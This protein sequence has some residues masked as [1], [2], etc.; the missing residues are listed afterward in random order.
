MVDKIIGSLDPGIRDCGLGLFYGQT[1]QWSK[2]VKNPKRSGNDYAACRSM[3]LAV[4][5]VFP[6]LDTLIIEFPRIYTAGK[7]VKK[8]DDGRA[9]STNPNDLL[10]LVGVGAAVAA[11]LPDTEIVSLYPD[12][13][14]GQV[15]KIAMNIRARGRLSEAE[16]KTVEARDP[17]PARPHDKGHNVWDAVGIGLHHVGR[18]DRVRIIA[19]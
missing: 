5:I 1:V 14:K 2:L 3:A 11:L 15:A 16:R 13:W 7:Q 19:R 10:P 9:R 12:E 18:L 8:D 4:S 17:D 6:R